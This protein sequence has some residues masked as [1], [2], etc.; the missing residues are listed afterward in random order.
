L[1][2]RQ[3]IEFM[4]TTA[5]SAFAI[6]LI[7]PRLIHPWMGAL[8]LVLFAAHLFFPDAEAR[9]I[10]A[11][12]YFGLAAVMVVVDRQRVLHLFTAGRD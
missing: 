7:A 5:V 4:L 2:D 1:D 3:S 6:L 9:R 10:F 12:V 8:L 11:F